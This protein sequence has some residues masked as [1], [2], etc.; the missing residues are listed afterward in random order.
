MIPCRVK[1]TGKAF[2]YSL[3]IMHDGGRL[4]MHQPLC[5]HHPPTECLSDGLVAQAYAEDWQLARKGTD[6]CKRHP[7]LV[8]STG[9]WGDEN[10][11]G[12]Q[13]TDALDI[14]CVVLENID[15]RPELARDT[16]R[17]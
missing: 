9:A 12:I 16:G 10:G 13:F 3:R 14:N 7:R 8:G 11:V 15:V 4:A 1:G 17:G 5:T 2:E 6:E